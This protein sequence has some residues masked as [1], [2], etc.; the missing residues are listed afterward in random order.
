VTLALR[1][2]A[3]AP[4]ATVITRPRGVSLGLGEL[5]GYRELAWFLV[6]RAIKPRYR[7]TVLGIGWAV[8]P[9]VALMFIFT[10][11]F[12]RVVHVPSGRSVPYPVFSYSGLLVWWFFSSGF[13][14]G[15]TSLIG[16]APFLTKIYFPRVLIPLST[17]LS[18]LFDLAIGCLAL[19]PLM[20]Y[21]DVL[22]GMELLALPAFV[23]LATAV[24][25]AGSLWV[26]AASVQYRDLSLAVPLLVQIWLFATP[27]IYPVGLFPD[28]WAT[29]LTIF[30]PMTPAV[31][32]FRWSLLGGDPPGWEAAL[33]AGLV[34]AALVG[35]LLFFSRM[36]RTYADEI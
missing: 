22:P 11:F 29:L 27:V 16:N 5:W 14:R 28:R 4:A 23:L 35:G 26:S 33:S 19:I 20:A 32:G 17:V 25:C 3:P 15:A 2:D 10:L 9:P 6:L 24:A 30:N 13:S 7:Q 36:E 18:A 8:I 21:Y 12:N 1:T 31:E 34:L